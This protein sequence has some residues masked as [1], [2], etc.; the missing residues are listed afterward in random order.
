MGKLIP[1]LL[2]LIGLA[3]GGGAGY[4]LRPPPQDETATDVCA[5]LPS[6]PDLTEDIPEGEPTVEYVKLNN[7]FVVPVVNSGTVSALVIMSLSLEVDIGSTE[8]VYRA[9]P[10]IR[11]ALL[12][13][14]FDH[15]NAGGFDGAFTGSA[16]MDVLRRALLE[17]CRSIL[18]ENVRN[19]L[20][21]D[22]VRQDTA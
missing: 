19:V 3:A 1:I 13:V 11:D 22:I 6:K 5:E 15:A 7:Q 16:N 9:E 10:K 8:A 12:Q 17:A 18:G 21:S 2:A 20:I 14:L 4:F